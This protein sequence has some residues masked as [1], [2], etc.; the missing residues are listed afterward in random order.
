MV[1]GRSRKFGALGGR[2]GEYNGV[3][4]KIFRYLRYLGGWM[5]FTLEWQHL[6]Y[7]HNYNLEWRSLQS[8]SH[9]SWVQST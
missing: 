3:N 5:L 7:G 9:T 1:Q 2:E 8:R 6:T 4:S